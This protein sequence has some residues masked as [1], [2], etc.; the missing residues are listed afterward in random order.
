M[1]AIAVGS[2]VT[3]SQPASLCFSERRLDIQLPHDHNAIYWNF[4]ETEINSE[5][6]EVPVICCL[7]DHSE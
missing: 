3:G 4:V 2:Y 5:H 7:R 1:E 6:S